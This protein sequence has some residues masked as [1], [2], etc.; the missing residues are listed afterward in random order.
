[1]I[2]DFT[3]TKAQAYNQVGSSDHLSQTKACGKR[4]RKQVRW[5]SMPLQEF[6]TKW[7]HRGVYESNMRGWKWI[8][9]KKRKNLLN[10]LPIKQEKLWISSALGCKQYRDWY[11][12]E[13]ILYKLPM[14]KAWAFRGAKPAATQI[15]SQQA[16]QFDL[17]RGSQPLSLVSNVNRG[18][19]QVHWY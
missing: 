5:K 12:E 16:N 4:K 15:S 1:M 3:H 14:Q 10:F 13:V 7:R 11:R 8:W 18:C 17:V 6:W 19:P 9:D 2:G